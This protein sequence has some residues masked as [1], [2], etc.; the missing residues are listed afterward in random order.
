MA[1]LVRAASRAVLPVPQTTDEAII[2]LERL[3][4]VGFAS[5]LI[6]TWTSIRHG[7]QLTHVS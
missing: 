7:L 2:L 6:S 1:G 4:R 5:T 3:Q